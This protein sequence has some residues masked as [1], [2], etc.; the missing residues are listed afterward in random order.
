MYPRLTER[1]QYPP[2]VLCALLERH[3]FTAYLGGLL[4]RPVTAAMGPRTAST[5]PSA[6]ST[7]SERFRRC[8]R[9]DEKKIRGGGPWWLSC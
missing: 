8:D 3:N 6:Y 1:T 9:H 4:G 7:H 5:G 2:F